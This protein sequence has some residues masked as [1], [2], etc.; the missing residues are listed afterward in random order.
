MGE[1]MGV[2]PV[3][4]LGTVAVGGVLLAVNSVFTML[5]E[6]PSFWHN[7]GGYPVG[8]RDLVLVAYYPLLGLNLLIG[9][10]VGALVASEYRVVGRGAWWALA[11]GALMW[12]TLVLNV[13]WLVANNVE[14]V[15]IGRELHYHPPTAD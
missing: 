10:G 1:A 2:R 4:W 7:A 6:T 11:V 9:V 8:L 5:K 3:L 15:L 14:N 12:A 13:G